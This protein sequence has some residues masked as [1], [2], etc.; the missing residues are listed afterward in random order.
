MIGR[1]F[2]V[3]VDAGVV[4]GCVATPMPFEDLDVAD[5]LGKPDGA[6][7]RRPS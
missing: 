7:M 3:G 6:A 2:R 4:P 1:V 5:R